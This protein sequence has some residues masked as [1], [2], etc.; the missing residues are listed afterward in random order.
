MSLA[1][2][3]AVVLD[4]DQDEGYILPKTEIKTNQNL[5][6]LSTIDHEPE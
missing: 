2:Q 6:A 1:T 5:N 3:E 4:D